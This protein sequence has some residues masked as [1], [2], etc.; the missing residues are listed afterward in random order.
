[1]EFDCNDLAEMNEEKLKKLLLHLGYTEDTPLLDK[2]D[3][4]DII[5]DE[6]ARECFSQLHSE[7]QDYDY[8]P[9]HPD[10]T[11]EEFKDHEN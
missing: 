11:V 8:S 7:G 1:M 10:E 4:L 5:I 9:W 3:L 6:Y 2:Q